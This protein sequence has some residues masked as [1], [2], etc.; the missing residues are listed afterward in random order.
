MHDFMND[1][2]IKAKNSITQ[3]TIGIQV[4][5]DELVMKF[6]SHI[7][8]QKARVTDVELR[9]SKPNTA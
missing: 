5:S 7:R 1:L 9:L 6:D 2:S 4:A 3:M 8:E